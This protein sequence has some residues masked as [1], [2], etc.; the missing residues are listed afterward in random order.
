MN[1]GIKNEYAII[2]E[3][4]MKKYYQLREHWKI[5]IK[6]IFPFIKDDDL[7]RAFSF[8]D[9]H[10]KPDIYIAY[11][12]LK[13]YIS[14]K[15]G[16]N[17]SIHQEYYYDFFKFLERNGLDKKIIKI[18]YFYHF[19]ITN[20]LSNNGLPF[21]KDEIVDKYKKYIIFANQEI[22]KNKDL[23]KRVINRAV[24]QGNNTERQIIDYFYYGNNEKGYLLTKNDIY[25]MV[26]KEK[27]EDDKFIHFGGLIYQPSG[28]KVGSRD[29]NYSRIKWP[30][31]S[32]KFYIDEII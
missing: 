7:L 10:A 24:I 13:K 25:R 26:L 16:T 11:K 2:E 23:I 18:I 30:I 19:G 27:K 29:R 20:K 15:T 4:N 5:I 8:N 21:T 32:V 9:K 1:D 6:I 14:I 31:L 17:P 22:N 28:R 12:G 3:I